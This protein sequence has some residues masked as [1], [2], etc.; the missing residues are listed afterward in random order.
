MP[1]G[2]VHVILGL[3]IGFAAFM[4]GGVSDAAGFLIDLFPKSKW[5]LGVVKKG[6]NDA[7]IAECAAR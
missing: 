5:R 3:W 2:G 1:G 4:R 6:N 7:E